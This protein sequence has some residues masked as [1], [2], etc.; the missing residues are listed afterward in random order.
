MLV[1]LVFLNTIWY[2][3]LWHLLEKFGRTTERCMVG[4]MTI[5]KRNLASKNFHQYGND[6]LYFFCRNLVVETHLGWDVI[7]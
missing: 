1:W 2:G 4:M 7:G 5:D 3:R 6:S